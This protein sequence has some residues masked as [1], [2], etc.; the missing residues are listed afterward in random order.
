MIISYNKKKTATEF[1]K[2][3]IAWA[4]KEQCTYKWPCRIE[5]LKQLPE[6]V[7]SC[8]VAVRFYE[9]DPSNPLLTK[10]S[11]NTVTRE[12]EEVELFFRNEKEHFNNKVR[13]TF[14]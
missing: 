1:V 8:N 5:E 6:S 7:F 2:G 9:I 11:E 13:T 4:T 3:K 14:K 10:L 12:L